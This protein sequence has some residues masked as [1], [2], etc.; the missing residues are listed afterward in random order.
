MIKLTKI[1]KIINLPVVSKKDNITLGRIEDVL[2]NPKTMEVIGYYVSSGFIVKR[3]KFLYASKILQIKKSLVYVEDKNSL[4]PYKK[5]YKFKKYKLFQKDT[6]GVGITLNGGKIGSVSDMI[7]TS[8]K[9]FA[10][11]ISNG[12]AED[13]LNGRKKIS[14]NNSVNFGNNNIEIN[15]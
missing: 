11:E 15:D 7:A 13:I 9:I 3:T 2:Y 8:N 1:S 14:I 5:F 10:L 12:F 6:A 4:I